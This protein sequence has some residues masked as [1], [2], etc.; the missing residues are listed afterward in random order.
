VKDFQF[1]LTDYLTNRK[2][3]LTAKI[4]KEKTISDALAGELKAAITEFKQTYR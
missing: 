2:S 4:A 1:K 3:D